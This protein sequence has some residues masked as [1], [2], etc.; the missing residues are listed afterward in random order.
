MA[1]LQRLGAPGQACLLRCCHPG[2]SSATRTGRRR[3][4]CRCD[5]S[6]HNRLPRW[7]LWLCELLLLL[8]LLLLHC[9][10]FFALGGS[11]CLAVVIFNL[12]LLLL[13]L[14]ISPHTEFDLVGAQ[15]LRLRYALHELLA[16]HLLCLGCL[17]WASRLL[18][19]AGAERVDE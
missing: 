17:S 19:L 1:E 3:C 2:P 11:S 12:L 18:G 14:R 15:L 6:A 16:G 7:L 4:P 9:N 8:L 13:F 10:D 5:W